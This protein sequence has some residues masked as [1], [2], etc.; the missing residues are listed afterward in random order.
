MKLVAQEKNKENTVL[1]SL[2]IKFDYEVKTNKQLKRITMVKN[3][4][5]KIGGEK[6]QHLGIFH[7]Q[8]N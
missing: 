1:H 6:I 3:G 7:L 2:V 5:N 8:Y 4:K